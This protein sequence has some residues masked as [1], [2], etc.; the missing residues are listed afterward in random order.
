[1]MKVNEMVAEGKL[2]LQQAEIM[3]DQ[4]MSAEDAAPFPKI[5]DEGK[6]G[7]KL[8]PNEALG[9]DDEDIPWLEENWSPNILFGDVEMDDKKANANDGSNDMN[10]A[11]WW[12]LPP[13][14]LDDDTFYQDED[15]NGDHEDALD[16]FEAQVYIYNT[17]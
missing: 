10:D 14:V 12:S 8:D 17:S 4:I 2:S 3:H 6:D 9:D 7:V 15:G 16:D 5:P 13:G 1:M 11:M